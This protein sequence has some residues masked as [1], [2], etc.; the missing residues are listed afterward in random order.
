[1]TRALIFV[2]FALAAFAQR[3][4]PAL[5]ERGGEQVA[6]FERAFR[7]VIAT[8][9]YHQRITS[10]SPRQSR[11][12]RSEVAP[13][14][15]AP[16]EGFIWMRRVL[17]V[18]RQDVP[19]SGDRLQTL[20]SVPWAAASARV[21]ALRDESARFNIGKIHRNVNDPTW[22][23]RILHPLVQRRFRWSD[24]GTERIDGVALR[25]LEFV[26]MTRPTLI[27]GEGR[28]IPTR[29]A[30]WIDDEGV[31]HRTTL[32]LSYQT[33]LGTSER[34]LTPATVAATITV[35]F[36]PQSGM[37]VLVPKK[38]VERYTKTIPKQ[39]F[40]D[41]FVR[42]EVVE[43]IQCEAIY[44]DYRRFETHTRILPPQEPR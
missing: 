21:G 4:H 17:E 6:T 23:I 26:E 16:D 2:G 38:M 1:M 19:D 42:A 44:T 28:D 10:V 36:G 32:D 3:D 18:D 37:D 31:T 12:M 43:E 35:D 29:G 13:L 5:L 11:V 41:Q 24:R 22:A 39:D 15:D 14:W 27:R 40:G 8:E 25:R 20:L 34:P 9:T 30:L 7:F 33:L